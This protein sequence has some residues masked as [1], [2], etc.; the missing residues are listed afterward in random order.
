MDMMIAVVVLLV[1]VAVAITWIGVL[2]V[3]TMR[4]M[5]EQ[6]DYLAPSWANL[7]SLDQHVS[8]INDALMRSE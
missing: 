7:R 6:M 1:Y 2:V 5:K 4:R 3:G 8:E